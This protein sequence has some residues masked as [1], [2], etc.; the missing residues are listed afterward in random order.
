M[1]SSKKLNLVVSTSPKAAFLAGS[2]R[3]LR[4][5]LAKKIPHH[6]GI[7]TMLQQRTSLSSSQPS[8]DGTGAVELLAG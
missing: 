2:G 4:I 8:G 6:A 5:F 3:F 1:V 7:V